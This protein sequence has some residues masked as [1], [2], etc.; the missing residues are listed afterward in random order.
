MTDNEFLTELKKG[1]NRFYDAGLN[2]ETFE[3]FPNLTADTTAEEELQMIDN[4]IDKFRAENGNI[5]DANF[6]KAL[7]L[8]NKIFISNYRDGIAARNLSKESSPEKESA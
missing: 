3:A 1:E 6:R 5:S 4:N 2:G 8:M 7:Q